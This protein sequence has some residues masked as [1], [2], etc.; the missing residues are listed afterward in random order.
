M[1]EENILH[2]DTLITT[3]N[4]LIKVG[5]LGL[6]ERIKSILENNELPK[7]TKHKRKDDLETS[8]YLIELSEE[9]IDI[10]RDIFLDLE[11]ANVSVEGNTTPLASLYGDIAD[12]WGNITPHQKT[13]N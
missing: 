4:E 3:Y 7:P 6:A 10:I 9:E 1:R 13:T 2:Y 8:K 11:V 5:H 12:I